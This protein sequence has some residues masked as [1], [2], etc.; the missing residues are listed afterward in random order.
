M[1]E[2]EI[3]PELYERLADEADALEL[4]VQEVAEM[5]IN[6]YLDA[7]NIV[8]PDFETLEDDV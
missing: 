3:S 4:S 8:P 7:D 2:I 5:A 1:Y 6:Q